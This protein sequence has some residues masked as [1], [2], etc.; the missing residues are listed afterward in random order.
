MRIALLQTSPQRGEK[1]KNLAEIIEQVE[2]LDADIVVLPELCTTGYFFLDRD[3]LVPMAEEAGSGHLYTCLREVADR[4]SFAVIAGYTE[5]DPV[6]GRLY[7]SSVA[8]LPGGGFHNYRK[9]H[10]FYRESEI[11]SYGDT[12]FGTFDYLGVRCGM[13]I[14]YD[15][16]FPE[17]ARSLALQGAELILHPSNLVSSRSVWRPA[18]IT[19]AL[20]NGVA[21]VTANRVGS[22]TVG[23]ETLT[24]TGGSMILGTRGEVLAEAGGEPTALTVDLTPESNRSRGINPHN[25]IWEDRRPEL[26]GKLTERPE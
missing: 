20:E 25:N 10:L 17:A 4:K 2:S 19:R 22:E 14:C 23:T 6:R 8:I 16:R 18:M 13:M 3:E 21:I 5:I 26:Y 9:S 1:E 12:G 7:N 15:W 24:F 11:F